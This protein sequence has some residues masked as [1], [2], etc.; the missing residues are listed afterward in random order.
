[1]DSLMEALKRRRMMKNDPSSYMEDDPMDNDVGVVEGMD[2][3]PDDDMGANSGSG[4]QQFSDLAPPLAMGISDSEPD[5]GDPMLTGDSEAMIEMPVNPAGPQ[6]G[7]SPSDL[8]EAGGEN[9]KG[10]RG[11]AMKKI[12]GML[13]K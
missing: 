5:G 7:V 12:K 1:M 10:F 9:Q 2:N 6:S 3:D 11:K 4:D 8:Y 13:G